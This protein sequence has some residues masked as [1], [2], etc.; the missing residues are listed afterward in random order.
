M[1]CLVTGAAGFIG[2]HLC[3]RLLKAGHTVAGL[4]AFI[5]YYP[6]SIKEGNLASLKTTTG[7]TF[8]E[9]DLRKDNVTAAVGNVDVVFH[10]GAMAGLAKSWTDFDL[11]Q[12]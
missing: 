11:Y 4:D 7:F 6:R 3:E 12:S 10:L 9:V 8:H 2:S 1:H 5:P